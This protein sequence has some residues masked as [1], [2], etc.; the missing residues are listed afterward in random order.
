[1]TL[2]CS[3]VDTARESLATIL[4]LP[5]ETLGEVLSIELDI[6]TDALGEELMKAA[7]AAG[8]RTDAEFSTVL[9]HA[10]RSMQPELFETVGLMPFAQALDHMWKALG[11][12]ATHGTF[13][14]EELA[15]LRCRIQSEKTICPTY[16]A[17]L[18]Q[19][20]GPF[21]FLIR[22]VACRAPAGCHD[23]LRVPEIVEDIASAA[24]PE[25]NL[26]DLFR[27]NSTPCIVSFKHRFGA[28]HLGPALEYVWRSDRGHSIA[29]LTAIDDAKACVPPDK[30]IC[31]DRLC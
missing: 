22:E 28:R 16:D 24:P 26:L 23:Y 13:S 15:N 4:A 19:C 6:E 14:S 7:H 10:T 27:E 2:D 20:G 1:M 31:V 12:L 11:S 18:R 5:P 30:I 29:G 9:H 21:G 17:K 3:T 25:W 8:A